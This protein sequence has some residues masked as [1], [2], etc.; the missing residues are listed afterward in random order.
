MGR[1]VV[2]LHGKPSDRR[3]A[4]MIEEYSTRL[5]SKVRLEFHNSKLSAEEYLSRIPEPSFILDENGEEMNSIQ[6]SKR[7]ADWT[8]QSED[9]HL[10]VGPADG[11]PKENGRDSLSLSSMTM[12]HELAAVVLMEQLYRSHEI[13]RGSQY[14]RI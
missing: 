4:G 10:A 12:P 14:H 1:I 13:Q 8:L 11:F 9:I 6:F 7:F 5:G 2:H 3:L